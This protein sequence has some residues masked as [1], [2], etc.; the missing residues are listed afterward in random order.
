MKRLKYLLLS[1][2]LFAIASW[3]IDFDDDFASASSG[4]VLTNGLLNLSMTASNI[5]S[6]FVVLA[7]KEY[8]SFFAY[9]A[10]DGI[11]STYW[12]NNVTTSGGFIQIYIGTPR[13]ATTYTI[14]AVAGP[15]AGSAPRSWDFKGSTDGSNWVTIS[16]VSNQTSWVATTPRTFN[17]FNSLTY[18]YYKWDFTQ[19]NNV[20]NIQIAE[21]YLYGLIP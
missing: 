9:Q 12:N 17:T 7:N 16:S 10:F 5:P 6:P 15:P 2:P 19:Q 20:N 3:E 1:I 13:M 4:V 14:R 11:T 18:S 21:I 8:K